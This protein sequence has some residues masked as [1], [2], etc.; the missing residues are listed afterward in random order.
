MTWMNALFTS[1]VT[2]FGTPSS[3]SSSFSATFQQLTYQQQR[4]P[5]GSF[6]A[7]GM[8][9]VTGSFYT[10]SPSQ[11]TLQ[12]TTMAVG[13]ESSGWNCR[14]PSAD[15]GRYTPTL[16]GQTG[17]PIGYGATLTPGG[18]IQGPQIPRTNDMATTAAIG[19]A[20]S[21]AYYFNVRDLHRQVNPFGVNTS[22]QGFMQFFNLMFGNRSSFV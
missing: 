15:Y 6:F 10:R 14:P 17:T 8:Q 2:P 18:Y 3:S 1:P 16:P 22:Q 20:G 12:M 5:A 7:G 19:E 21:P 13:E 4:G 11:T 9:Q